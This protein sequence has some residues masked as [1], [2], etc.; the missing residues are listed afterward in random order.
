MDTSLTLQTR[1]E[2][3]DPRNMQSYTITPVTIG[4]RKK[5]VAL[6]TVTTGRQETKSYLYHQLILA[7]R[8]PSQQRD[9]S[10]RDSRSFRYDSLPQDHHLTYSKMPARIRTWVHVPG[11]KKPFETEL[12][13]RTGF[14]G[15]LWLALP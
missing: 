2:D 10:S 6:Q 11:K 3:S 5:L 9:C 8:D 4:N 7:R 1:G 14:L 12:Y 15:S 13:P